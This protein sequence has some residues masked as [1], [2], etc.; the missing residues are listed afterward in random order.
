MSRDTILNLAWRCLFFLTQNPMRPA[1]FFY[2]SDLGA[3]WNYSVVVKEVGNDFSRVAGHQETAKYVKSLGVMCTGAECPVAS[4]TER[5]NNKW[6]CPPQDGDPWD[7]TAHSSVEDWCGKIAD[8]RETGRFKRG[9]FRVVVGRDTSEG[10][11]LERQVQDRMDKWQSEGRVTLMMLTSA[12]LRL[13]GDYPPAE[14]TM[15]STL[16][17]KRSTSIDMRISTHYM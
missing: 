4:N 2:M 7:T 8:E 1:G 10:S 13:A 11:A 12:A 15:V 6:L 17:S 5:G 16:S 9:T 3:T 14:V